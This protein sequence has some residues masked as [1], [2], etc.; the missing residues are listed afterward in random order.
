MAYREQIP[1][2]AGLTTRGRGTRTAQRTLGPIGWT[3]LGGA[4][5]LWL[6]MAL[7]IVR[8]GRARAGAA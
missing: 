3:L 6:G 7:A 4:A 5:G 2:R 1:R 8:G